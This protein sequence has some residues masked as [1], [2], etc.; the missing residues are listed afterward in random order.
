MST[1]KIVK[2]SHVCHKDTIKLAK[3]DTLHRNVNSAARHI[4]GLFD[5]TAAHTDSL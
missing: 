1:L 5:R 3:S 4:F 2:W